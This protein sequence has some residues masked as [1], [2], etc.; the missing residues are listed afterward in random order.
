MAL[1]IG[2]QADGRR[3]HIE[4][5]ER[6]IRLPYI[7]PFVA[8]VNLTP[9]EIIGEMR[10]EEYVLAYDGVYVHV[11]LDRRDLIDLLAQGYRHEDY[12]K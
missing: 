2:G 3:M 8:G 10:V 1:F 7:E 9:R 5:E 12:R 4:H 6:Y 11:S